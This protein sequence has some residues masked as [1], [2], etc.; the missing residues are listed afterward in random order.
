MALK[1]FK[2]TTWRL[3]LSSLSPNLDSPLLSLYPLSLSLSL[4]LLLPLLQT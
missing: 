1:Q 2:A 3:M 4:H